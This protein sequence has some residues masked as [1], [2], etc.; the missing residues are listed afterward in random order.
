MSWSCKHDMGR[1]FH[2]ESDSKALF[3][4]NESDAVA[5][6]GYTSELHHELKKC[7]MTTAL[8]LGSLI[9]SLVRDQ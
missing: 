3:T 1:V 7:L 6:K 8:R 2:P 4:M 9:C 5:F